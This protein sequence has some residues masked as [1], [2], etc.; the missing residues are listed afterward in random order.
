MIR[1]ILSSLALI[2]MLSVTALADGILILNDRGYPPAVGHPGQSD[3]ERLIHPDEHKPRPDWTVDRALSRTGVFSELILM[4]NLTV[5]R[6]N[7]YVRVWSN[8]DEEE[9]MHRCPQCIRDTHDYFLSNSNQIWI[10]DGRTL[11]DMVELLIMFYQVHYRGVPEDS[12]HSSFALGERRFFH[13]MWND[14]W[15]RRKKAQTRAS[16]GSGR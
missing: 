6:M 13:S 2:G 4:M 10:G 16:G 3:D 5:D 1:T 12:I 11:D 9:R 7:P 15:E 8:V 14:V